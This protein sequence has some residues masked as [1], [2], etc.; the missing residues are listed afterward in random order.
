MGDT[1]YVHSC[2][3]D[4]VEFYRKERVPLS[5]I[6]VKLFGGASSIGSITRPVSMFKNHNVESA[7]RTL[8]DYGFSVQAL[9]TGGALTRELF[10]DFTTGDAF[11]RKFGNQ[12]QSMTTAKGQD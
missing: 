4:M 10:F 8:E 12:D 11:V 1:H 7:L 2:I 6:Q 5:N 3:N 9:D